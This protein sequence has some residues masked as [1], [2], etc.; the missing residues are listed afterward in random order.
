MYKVLGSIPAQPKK[1]V[2]NDHYHQLWKIF[3][4]VSHKQSI[5]TDSTFAEDNQEQLKCVGLFQRDKT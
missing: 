3:R 1:K 5:T 2:I 4:D